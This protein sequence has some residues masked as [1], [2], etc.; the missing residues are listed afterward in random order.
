MGEQ[1]RVEITNCQREVYR[2]ASGIRTYTVSG[3]VT[4][5]HDDHEQSS[6][7]VSAWQVEFG[8]FACFART[9]NVRDGKTNGA[10]AIPSMSGI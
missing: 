10:S 4:R 7:I 9:D 8:K 1:S 5:F 2:R 6:G 3:R